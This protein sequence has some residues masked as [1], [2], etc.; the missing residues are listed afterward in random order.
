MIVKVVLC[1]PDACTYTCINIFMHPTREYVYVYTHTHTAPPQ[2]SM[3]ENN[4][5]FIVFPETKKQG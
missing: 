2:N 1:S 3:F 5:C 4:V